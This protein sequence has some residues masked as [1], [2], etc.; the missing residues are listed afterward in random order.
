[1]PKFPQKKSTK[2]SVQLSY[3]SILIGILK[4]ILFA[5][6]QLA[7]HIVVKNFKIIILK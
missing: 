4:Y 6:I 2:R 3:S 5:I 7:G 1:M